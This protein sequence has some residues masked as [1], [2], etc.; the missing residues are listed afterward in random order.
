M[1]E[2]RLHD[3]VPSGIVLPSPAPGRSWAIY[4]VRGTAEELDGALRVIPPVLTALGP[5][6]V[7]NEDAEWWARLVAG[8]ARVRGLRGARLVAELAALAEEVSG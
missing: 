6:N 4:E 5:V 3:L 2:A 8:V 7:A 1:V